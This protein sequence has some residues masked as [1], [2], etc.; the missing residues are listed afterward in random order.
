[1]P[2]LHQEETATAKRGQVQRLETRRSRQAP[3]MAMTPMNTIELPSTTVLALIVLCNECARREDDTA[4]IHSNPGL[5][6][7]HLNKARDWRA[8]ADELEKATRQ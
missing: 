3:E 4:N 6:Q 5:I 1:M 2:P 7:Y 8:L